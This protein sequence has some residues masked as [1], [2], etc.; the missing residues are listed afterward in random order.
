MSQWTQVDIG[1]HSKLRREEYFVEV[2][3][4][5]SATKTT[6]TFRHILPAPESEQVFLPVSASNRTNTSERKT[7][8]DLRLWPTHKCREH[9]DL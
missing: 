1:Q 8:C 6:C 5:A 7:Q 9:S 2:N 4:M 3:T